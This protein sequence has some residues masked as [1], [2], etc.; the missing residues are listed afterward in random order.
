[1]KR[2]LLLAMIGFVAFGCSK[3]RLTDP[4]D[5]ELDD[6]LGRLS[7]TGSADYYILPE[8]DDFGSI[9]AGVNNPITAEKVE[10]GKL[11]FYETA[12]AGDAMHESSRYT[13][14]CATCHLP[15]AGFMPGRKQGIADGGMGMGNDRGMN[16]DYDESELDTQAGRALSLLNVSY[17]TNTTWTGKFGANHTNADTENIWDVFEDT[18]INYTGLDG[19][20][21]QL[22]EGQVLHRMKVDEYV[23]DELGYRALYDAAFPDYPVEERYGAET[24]AFAL[25]AYIRTL[26]S[27]K[28]PFQEWLKGERGALTDMQKEGALLFYGKAGCVRCHKGPSM[29]ANEYHAIGVKDMYDSHGFNTSVDDL[30]NFGRGGFTGKEEDLYK[31][32]VPTIYNMKDS[33]FYFH[34]SSKHTLW[35]V[36]EYFNDAI[37]ENERVDRNISPL[38]HPLNLTTIEIQQLVAFLA[39]GLRDP[40]LDRY[41]PDAVLSGNCFPNNDPISREIMGCE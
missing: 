19:I 14:S 33:P 34:G 39:D 16:E 26:L 11:F 1:M 29:S 35:G 28:A 20:E 2:F 6:L 25:A 40:D 4:L 27:N 32:K 3:D 38:F 18:H 12:L 10:L 36:V 9:I 22:I 7:P 30:R 23:L 21:A 41:V 5:I 17:V 31:F 15:E 24:T 8:S 37:P 13:Y